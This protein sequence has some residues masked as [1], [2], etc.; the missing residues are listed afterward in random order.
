[1]KEELELFL[2]GAD[3]IC[4][5]CVGM[6]SSKETYEWLRAAISRK[7][8]NQPFKIT[9]I[10]IYHPPENREIQAFA[11]LVRDEEYF[12]P[13]LLIEGE[14]VGEGNPRLKD[15]YRKMEEYGYK[16]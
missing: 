12:Y 16:A 13:V 4:A 10:D 5:S 14:V 15:V 3:Q 6:P 8:P 7:Y 9:Y 2:Y 1:M 11:E